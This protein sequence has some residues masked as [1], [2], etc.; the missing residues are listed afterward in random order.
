MKLE[1][2]PHEYET[3]LLIGSGFGRAETETV[4]NNLLLMMQERSDFEPFTW[5]EYE[6]FC[7]HKVSHREKAELLRMV[8]NGWLD[9]DEDRFAITLAFL[10]CIEKFRKAR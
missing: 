4:A 1:R 2:K 7:T 9:T 6:T 3:G 10:G 8:D 5:A